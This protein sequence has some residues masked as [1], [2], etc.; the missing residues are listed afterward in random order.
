MSHGWS[1]S[2]LTIGT[3]VRVPEDLFVEPTKAVERLISATY[4][5]ESNS[6]I[7][8]DCRFQPAFNTIDPNANHYRMMISWA[9]L[10]CGY[11]RIYTEDGHLIRAYR[12]PGMPTIA[13]CKEQ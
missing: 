10:W 12:Q 4:I 6:G 5:G 1:A 3:R 8:L 9:S 2:N 13:T 7:L 11:V